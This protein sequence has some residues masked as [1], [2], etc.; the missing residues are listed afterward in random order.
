MLLTGRPWYSR[1]PVGPSTILL[2]SRQR[3]DAVDAVPEL[4]VRRLVRVEAGGH[5][6][7][8]HIDG[9]GLQTVAVDA[10]SLT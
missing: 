2:N 9:D 5:D 7:G 3:D 4:A 10:R 8:T 6:D 1:A